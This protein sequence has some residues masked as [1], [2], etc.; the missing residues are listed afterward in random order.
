MPDEEKPE[1]GAAP[2]NGWGAGLVL[3][4][5]L[6][7]AAPVL[8]GTGLASAAWGVVRQ[9][10]GWLAG[11]LGLAAVTILVRGRQAREL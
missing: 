6:C 5:A 7:C 3:A 10:W 1:Q 2:S 11:G 8:I 9:H 4:A